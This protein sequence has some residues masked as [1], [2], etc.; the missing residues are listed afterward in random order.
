MGN[1]SAWSHVSLI[2]MN[3]CSPALLTAH[4][5]VH[6]NSPRPNKAG[7]ISLSFLSH[8]GTGS[9]GPKKELFQAQTRQHKSMVVVDGHNLHT[10]ALLGDGDGVELHDMAKTLECSAR[11]LN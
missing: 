1:H 7:I 2:Y 3:L 4:V 11:C 9:C 8:S 10:E 5:F 6:L